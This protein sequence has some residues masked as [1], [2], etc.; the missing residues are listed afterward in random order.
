MTEFKDIKHELDGINEAVKGITSEF[1]GFGAKFKDAREAMEEQQKSI[2]A[3]KDAVDGLDIKMGK[4]GQYQVCTKAQVFAIPEVKQMFE[5]IRK[6]MA[7]NNGP[8]GGYLVHTDYLNYV[9]EQVRDIDE[10]RANATVL[11]T[12]S[13]AMEIP[14]EDTDAGLQWV[15]ETEER[16]SPPR[17]D[18]AR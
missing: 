3:L 17:R 2:D 7:V 6:G 14:V 9:F 4:N 18:S 15:G 16:R 11:S 13:S 12:G 1:Q 10:I 8:S 5:G